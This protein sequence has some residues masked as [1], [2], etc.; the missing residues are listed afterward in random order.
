MNYSY[1]PKVT[2]SFW[3]FLMKDADSRLTSV[4]VAYQVTNHKLRPFVAFKYGSGGTED[5]EEPWQTVKTPSVRNLI[6]KDGFF[7]ASAYDAFA[8]TGY[9]PVAYVLYVSPNG[10][11]VDVE[12]K[13][14]KGYA[15]ALINKNVEED[16]FVGMSWNDVKDKAAQVHTTLSDEVRQRNGFSPW[17]VGSMQQW[18]DGI[19]TAFGAKFK[20]DLSVIENSQGKT[21]QDYIFDHYFSDA[22]M[23]MV[24]MTY[25]LWTSTEGPKDNTKQYVINMA[26]HTN[27]RFQEVNKTETRVEDYKI[28]MRP[29]IAF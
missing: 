1:M 5:F 19:E 24:G 9:A 25:P 8:A 29:F 4:N 27:I 7:Y 16:Q 2:H 28:G 12:G 13:K 26:T 15:M 14:Y 6:G 21:W 22:K 18:K 11:T 20:D 17:F 23:T 10:N 3:S